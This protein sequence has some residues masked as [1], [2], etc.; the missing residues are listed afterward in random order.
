MIEIA[1]KI[2][3]KRYASDRWLKR[4]WEDCLDANDKFNFP[5]GRFIP[6]L[7]NEKFRYIIECDGS[8]HDR[9]DVRRKDLAKDSSYRSKGYRVFRLRA[10][11]FAALSAIKTEV[12]RIRLIK[13]RRTIL[14][15]SNKNPEPAPN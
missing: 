4:E 13:G 9:K 11:D 14:R 5:L 3:A 7:V 8:I 1:E 15:K 10:Y 6:D 2:E 12:R